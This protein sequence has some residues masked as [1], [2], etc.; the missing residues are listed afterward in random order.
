MNEIRRSS[1][2]RASSSTA[3]CAGELYG[4]PVRRMPR[5][6]RSPSPSFAPSSTSHSRPL[7]AQRHATTCPATA[8][9]AGLFPAPP[10][11]SLEDSRTGRSSRRLSRHRTRLPLLPCRAGTGVEWIGRAPN[12]PAAEQGMLLAVPPMALG[13]NSGVPPR[14][15]RCE[16]RW[17]GTEAGGQVSMRHL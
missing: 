6:I 15:P 17:R 8:L 16:R 7:R 10:L 3:R 12:Y 14:G 11:A 13:A 1:R 5:S 9:C 2:A 4:R